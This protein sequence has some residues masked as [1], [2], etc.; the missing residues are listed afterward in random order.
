MIGSESQSQTKGQISQEQSFTQE[1]K[2]SHDSIPDSDPTIMFWD[3]ILVKPAFIQTVELVPAVYEIVEEQ[4]LVK[5][6]QK[7]IKVQ[8]AN[9]E[10]VR[11]HILVK[12]ES[13]KWLPKIDPITGKAEICQVCKKAGNKDCDLLF[14]QKVP[15]EYK[16]ITKKVLT[17]PN[18]SPNMEIPAEYKTV[19]K[20]VLKSPAIFVDEEVPAE[21]KIVPR[22]RKK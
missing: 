15:A 5:S 10:T 22:Q 11:E 3:T 8:P 16:T 12:K 14:W 21:Y 13:E 4:V 1:I 6:C 18:C 19:R 2:I 20:K 9:Y 17:S 7:I